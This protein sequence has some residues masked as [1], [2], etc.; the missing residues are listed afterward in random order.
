[1]KS[2]K[3]LLK[4]TESEELYTN[5]VHNALSE[6]GKSY[7]NIASAVKSIRNTLMDDV[8]IREKW[9]EA[10]VPY[11]TQDILA[12]LVYDHALSGTSESFACYLAANPFKCK[13]AADQIGIERESFA[14]FQSV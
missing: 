3:S 1:M 13:R 2:I 7:R 6:Y 11:N 10:Y 9:S 14:E 8:E 4:L 12:E 5:F